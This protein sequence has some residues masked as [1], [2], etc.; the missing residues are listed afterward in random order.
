MEELSEPRSPPANSCPCWRV[1]IEIAE[2]SARATRPPR[3]WLT[4]SIG[5]P[6]G[7][8]PQSRRKSLSAFGAQI[9]AEGRV[10]EP[11]SSILLSESTI[12]EYPTW[13]V[14]VIERAGSF[15]TFTGVQPRRQLDTCLSSS[16]FVR[17]HASPRQH[18]VY[19]QAMFRRFTG[20]VLDCRT[21]HFDSITNVH[22]N[23]LQHFVCKPGIGSHQDRA[24]ASTR[25]FHQS[26][27][28][29]VRV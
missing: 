20:A 23:G 16:E 6:A 1:D 21:T 29:G 26:W 3:L 18:S 2:G 4:T 10:V 15:V 5:V 17:G 22:L 9:H 12:K 14:F 27:G 19:P 24:G 13:S 28:F 7:E 8:V 11:H 25:I